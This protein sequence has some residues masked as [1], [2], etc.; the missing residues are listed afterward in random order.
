MNFIN[1]FEFFLPI[2][3]TIFQETISV[4]NY[5]MAPMTNED[6]DA[7]EEVLAERKLSSEVF[8]TAGDLYGN[9]VQRSLLVPL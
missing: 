6:L 3:P 4:A 5:P 8:D 7:L 1:F 2:L 9:I